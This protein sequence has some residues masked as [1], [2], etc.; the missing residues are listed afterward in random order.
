MWEHL[1]DGVGNTNGV[2]S[3][4]DATRPLSG[5]TFAR[6]LI[7]TVSAG[8]QGSPLVAPRVISA[9]RRLDAVW[10]RHSPPQV[11][12]LRLTGGGPPRTVPISDFDGT[13]T[14]GLGPDGTLLLAGE[15]FAP[16]NGVTAV[17]SAV[18]GTGETTGSTT[19]LTGSNAERQLDDMAVG[20][21]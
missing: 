12:D 17:F 15:D 3:V 1:I 19:Q 2:T 10:A 11:I 13:M 20:P 7:D 21:D 6:A 18:V 14:A 8:R 4:F 5:G 16:P 9:G